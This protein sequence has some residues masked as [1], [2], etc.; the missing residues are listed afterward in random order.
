MSKAPTP[1]FADILEYKKAYRADRSSFIPD[2]THNAMLRE[3]TQLIYSAE[4]TDEVRERVWKFCMTLTSYT[5]APVTP[6]DYKRMQKFTDDHELIDAVLEALDE[7]YPRDSDDPRDELDFDTIGYYYSIALISQSQYRREDCLALLNTLTQY[8]VNAKN[9]IHN[10]FLR[11]MKILS[12]TYPDL[13]Q[14]KTAL[15]SI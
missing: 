2:Q 12:K 4:M 1:T 14:F 9:N 7:Y 13:V 3:M 8:F 15:E 6:A 11:N 10:V 5:H